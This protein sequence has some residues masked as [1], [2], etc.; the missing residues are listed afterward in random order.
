MKGD[1]F[2]FLGKNLTTEG[3]I[4]PYSTIG[5]DYYG[6]DK[7]TEAE[8]TIYDE[9]FNKVKTFSYPFKE[10][11]Y[12]RI[13]M[14]A[15]V[16]ITKKTLIRTYNDALW[17]K[18]STITTM[19]QFKNVITQKLGSRARGDGDETITDDNFFIDDNGNFAFHFS[20]DSWS[21]YYGTDF[22]DD[23]RVPTIEQTYLY[24]NKEGKGIFSFDG[25]FAIELDL[26]NA[27]FQQEEGA[28]IEEQTYKE[29]IASRTYI[30]DYDYICNESADISLSQNVFNKDDKFEYLVSSYKLTTAPTDKDTDFDNGLE[31]IDLE[32]GKFK[33]RK[34]VQDKYYENIIKVIN[35]DGKELFNYNNGS[36]GGTTYR[37]NGKIYISTYE[38]N[39][40]G[41]SSYV[42][43]VLDETGTGITELAR[44]KQVPAPKFFN[45][46]GMQVD[47]NTKGIV[48]QK[49]GAKY[50]NK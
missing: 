3:K 43:Y 33:V 11:T 46:Q 32:N 10:F 23:K 30:Y 26:A 27:N 4:I 42:I 20:D 5:A 13:P 34:T 44:T 50:L 8:F 6:S 28:N 36:K 15:L 17:E 35:E 24:Y 40:N 49:G 2:S 21:R 22:V 7:V 41:D 29:R 38:G 37:I 14:T 1:G 31:G 19:E 18:D 16:D 47:K 12:K 9:A 48:I 39:G 25:I 45:L